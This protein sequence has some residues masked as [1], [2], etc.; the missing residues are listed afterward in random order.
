MIM[1]R[2]FF[3]FLLVV[4]LSLLWSAIPAAPNAPVVQDE[5]GIDFEALNFRL[6]HAAGEDG[7]LPW[8]Q[9]QAPPDRLALLT[10]PFGTSGTPVP[11]PDGFWPLQ[12]TL[13]PSWSAGSGTPT[14]T[15]AST[16]YVQDWEALHKQ[17]LSGEA[18]FRG[19]RRVSNV[20]LSSVNTPAIANGTITAT[21][22]TSPDGT[23]TAYRVSVGTSEY[24]VYWPSNGFVVGQLNVF[25]I[26][27]RGFG[28]SIGKTIP[29]WAL[30]EGD[31]R[32]VVTLTSEWKRYSVTD[33]A[34]TSAPIDNFRVGV[35]GEGG[36]TVAV[37]DEFEIGSGQIEFVIGQSNQNPSE[38]VSVGVLSAPYHGANVDGVKYF[39]T[40]NGN[41]VTDNV[42]TEATGA[43]ITSAN[44][45]ALTTDA[46]GPFGY[47][48]EGSRENVIL[49]SNTLG[50][51]WTISN[52]A[53]MEAVVADQYVSVDG[54]TTMDKLQPKATTAVHSLDQAFT[55]TAAKYTTCADLR[56]VSAT[57]QRWVAIINNDGTTTWG[58]SFDLLNGVVGAVSAGAT[59]TIEATGTANVYRACTTNTANAA[60]A[61]GTVKISL[62]ATDTATLESAARAGTET[63]GA[64][65]VQHEVGTFPSS[66]ITTTTVAVTRAADSLTYPTASNFSD[67]A[68]TMYAEVHY[69]AWANA[70]GSIIGSATQGMMPLATNSGVKGYDGTNTVNGTA[71]T[72][73]GVV[74]MGVTWTGTDMTVAAGGTAA[75]AGTYDTTWNLSSIGIG[76]GCFCSTRNTRVWL[77]ALSSSQLTTQTVFNEAFMPYRVAWID[78]YR[79]EAANDR[80][81][82]QRVNGR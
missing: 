18:R 9:H 53:D 46:G 24:R 82:L 68:G 7:L 60:A 28:G 75:V 77:S 10:L 64:G 44:S 43:P 17:V 6:R 4:L 50:T 71:G 12:T 79:R 20:L 61:A 78:E 2:R 42:V 31:Q 1:F 11:I 45:S 16:A 34:A 26:F 49:Q 33:T 35:T 27:L 38:Y 32:K 41:T 39:D 62:N 37:S 65:M 51:T 59:S 72:P 3:S 40:L 70:T 47:Q 5:Q 23:A 81:Y 69:D 58:A 56:Y 52:A 67:T 19:A 73:S 29:V 36:G 13:V 14:F 8:Q 80:S 30:G 54:T 76:L 25:S 22:V 66:R 15:R 63:L 48:A 21:G 74:K 55:F 57:P